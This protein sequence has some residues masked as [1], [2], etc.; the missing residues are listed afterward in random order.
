MCR[1]QELLAQAA[2]DAFKANADP[3]WLGCSKADALQ[4]VQTERRVRARWQAWRCWA[5]RQRLLRD[6]L[7]VGA[8]ACR[9]GLLASGKLAVRC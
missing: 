8:V 9:R 3:L 7:V 2:V 1:D 6:R 4:S 5:E